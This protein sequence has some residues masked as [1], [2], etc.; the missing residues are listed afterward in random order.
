MGLDFSPLRRDSIRSAVRSGAVID[1]SL[2]DRSMAL[3]F[4]EFG[5]GPRFPGGDRREIAVLARFIRL[6]GHDQG[7]GRR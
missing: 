7:E 1:A 2:S 5:F 3:G 6:N 4:E